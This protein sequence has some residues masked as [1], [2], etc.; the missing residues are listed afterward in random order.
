LKKEV[1]YEKVLKI[2]EEL[3]KEKFDS[4]HVSK[5]DSNY[6][7]WLKQDLY[8][9]T[10]ILKLCEEY[11]VYGK[12]L[13][14]GIGYAYLAVLI[15][16]LLNYEV[17]GIDESCRSYITNPVWKSLLA[18]ENIKFETCDIIHESLCFKDKS[19][20]L[21]TCCEV[22]EHITISPQKIFNEIYRV[23]TDNGTFILTT[24]NFASFQNRVALL[25]G[26][27]CLP[28]FPDK[29]PEDPAY[30]HWREYIPRELT[31]MLKQSGFKI[32]KLHMSDCWDRNNQRA[33]YRYL[34]KL[35]PSLRSD[36]MIVAKKS[37]SFDNNRHE[38]KLDFMQK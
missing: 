12:C 17:T 26:R 37:S 9:Y 13:E 24:P 34:P 18:K 27:N 36:I 2:I 1:T 35:V 38:S 19:F 21:V 3:A 31:K 25:R 28:L 11:T 10:D 20:D 14:I 6:S 30:R 29:Q 4:G 32:E 8:H 33:Y 7:F 23:L 16:K 5:G 15:R 22:I